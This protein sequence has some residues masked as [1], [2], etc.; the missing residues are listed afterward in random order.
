[1]DRRAFLSWV[2]IGALASYL[3]VVIAACTS[4]G[5][6]SETAPEK[7]KDTA[8]KIDMSVR[9]DGFQAL[10]TIEQLEQKGKILDRRNA[11]QPVLIFRHPEDNKLS[12]INPMCT[13]QGCTVKLDAG[14]KV[15][16]CLCH[17]SQ[18][19]LDGTVVKGPAK[20]PLANFEI[21]QENNLVL[22]KV[23]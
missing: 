3:P 14:A 21:K 17:G 4:E 20:K 11:P 9:E 10:G 22:V 15:F 18:F 8:V 6:K 19:N 5:Q 13:H 1:M 16:A 2:G 12:A 7:P 23:S